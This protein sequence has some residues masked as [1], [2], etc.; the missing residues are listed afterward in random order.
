MARDERVNPPFA[1]A[2]FARTARILALPQHALSMR[3]AFVANT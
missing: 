2:F 3:P 1:A